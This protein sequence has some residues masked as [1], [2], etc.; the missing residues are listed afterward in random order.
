MDSNE[1][2][3]EKIKDGI[4][5]MLTENFKLSSFDLVDNFDIKPTQKYT[6]ENE[7]IFGTSLS[8]KNMNDGYIKERVNSIKTQIEQ[9]LDSEKEFLYFNKYKITYSF[10]RNLVQKF[11]DDEWDTIHTIEYYNFETS[12]WYTCDDV[13]MR[14][15]IEGV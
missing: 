5:I 8:L 13:D 12:I 15:K 11:I 10:R 6:F 3:L 2:L 4:K 1:N 7:M 14:L 9:K